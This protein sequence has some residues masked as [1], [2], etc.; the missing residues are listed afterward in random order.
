MSSSTAVC[1]SGCVLSEC[2]WTCPDQF[3][4]EVEDF[5]EFDAEIL[6]N[7]KKK[8]KNKTEGDVP[9]D[10]QDL[11]NAPRAPVGTDQR[12]YRR[13][14]FQTGRCAGICLFYLFRAIVKES[15]HIIIFVWG[16]G[17]MALPDWLPYIG[18]IPNVI[19]GSDGE[20]EY[21]TVR[22]QLATICR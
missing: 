4:S 8:Q 2:D 11:T 21:S 12:A 5:I 10:R 15:N 13:I 16:V 14:G 7:I 3:F 9:T 22:C 19:L 20:L 18:M 1:I 17:R 6:C